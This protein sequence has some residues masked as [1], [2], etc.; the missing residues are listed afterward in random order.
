MATTLT[1][2]AK[3]LIVDDHPNTAAMLAR[4][5]SKFDTPIEVMTA[6]SAEEALEIIG[7]GFV[8]ILITDF[9]MSGMNGLDLIEKLKGDRKP[10]HTIMITAYDTP[11]LK[12][13]AN[14]LQV[15]DYLVKPVQPEKIREIVGRVLTEIR[16][17]AKPS[18]TPQKEILPAKILIA[19][20]NPDNVRLLSVRLQNEG[21]Q[22]CTAFDGQETLDKIR[23]EMPDLVLLDVNMPKKDGFEVLLE[24]RADDAINHI[25]VIVVTAARIGAKDVREGLTLGADDYVTKP[26]DWR[27]LSAR[28]RTKLRVKQ[29]EDALR[30]RNQ[31]LGVLPE[32]S[33][34]LGE[35]R[36][37]EELTATVLSRSVAA[38]NASNGFLFTFNPDGSVSMQLHGSFNFSPWSWDELRTRFI[39][40][41]VVSQIIETGEGRIIEDTSHDE[42]WLKI[43]NDPTRSAIVIPL[44]GRREVIGAL[45]LT[46]NEKN[47]FNTEHLKLVQAIASQAAIAIEN[48]Q[49]VAV[50]RKRVNELVALNQLTHQISQFTR[51]SDLFEAVPTLVK[52]HLNYPSVALWLKNGN[53]LELVKL[54]GESNSPRLSLLEIAPQ[55]AAATGQ[56]AQFSGPI[57]ERMGER[58]GSGAPPV[59]STIAVPIFWNRQVNGV[60]SLVSSRANAFQESDR[61]LI[62]TLAAQIGIV[63]ERIKLFESVEQEQKRL[64]AVLRAAAD[65]I[66]VLSNEGRLQIINPAGERLFTDVTALV[67]SPLPAE[68]GYDGLIR[69]VEK[70]RQTGN[71]ERAE[72]HWP[73]ERTFSVLVAPIEEGGEVAVLHD[74]SHFMAINQLKN[75]FLATASHDL[76][77]PI[78]TVMG[79]SDLIQRVGPLNEMQADFLRRIRNSAQQMQ[80]LVLNLLEIARLEME[81]DLKKERV[82]L[83]ALLKEIFEEFEAQGQAKQHQ[84]SL[85][86]PEK[87][88]SVFGDRMRLQ[89][90]A[91][92]LLG[93]AIKYTPNGGHIWVNAHLTNGKVRVDVRDTGIGIPEEALPHLFQKF[94]RVHTDATQDIE[95]NGL[96]L[97]IVKAIVEQHGGTITVESKEGE[98]S[99]FS[100]TL[101]LLP[102]VVEPS[103][104]A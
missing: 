72:I 98:G 51:S 4:V 42:N 50:E 104:S 64:S 84:M 89:Q 54:E 75:E 21:Y 1:K 47:F 82:N 33:K 56:P 92:N 16:P 23:S 8:D 40:E 31:A 88:I 46:H 12:I 61:V 35:T 87:E 37:I 85:E 63:V 57:D 103:P 55:Q 95:G 99:C 101:S 77:N 41:G 91:R 100:F 53:K 68:K 97:A 39:S 43:P 66:L 32:I 10:F 11:G 30:K 74:V 67:G 48:A 49:L 5:L 27:E 26:V 80:D 93:N 24:M 29:A 79:Y 7:E 28:I 38:L 78:F 83:S 58:F 44:S 70:A 3:I 17:N 69:V 90:V 13:S 86:L 19:D 18:A 22:F 20:D 65:A 73:D 62:E 96:G 36:D 102:D 2:P 71:L 25:P 52:R 15:N 6:Q 76:K 94:Y 60:L 45:V 59:M 9:M 81:T 34:E 14:R